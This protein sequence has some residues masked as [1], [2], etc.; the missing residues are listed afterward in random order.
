MRWI[1]FILLAS[2]SFAVLSGCA[3]QE[4]ASGFDNSKPMPVEDGS[5]PTK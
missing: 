5:A 4:E 3:K 1:A 2:L